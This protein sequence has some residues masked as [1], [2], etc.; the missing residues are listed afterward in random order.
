MSLFILKCTII[1]PF[2]LVFKVVN[3]RFL[4]Y[5]KE[6]STTVKE[7]NKLSTIDLF[8]I[9]SNFKNQH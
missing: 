9:D 7:V 5:C 8:V 3:T 2:F 1:K 6:K 4:T